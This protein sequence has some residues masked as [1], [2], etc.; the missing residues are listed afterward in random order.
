M[1]TFSEIDCLDV[2]EF[3]QFLK[4]QRKVDDNIIYAL[5]R[6]DSSRHTEKVDCA[7]MWTSLAQIHAERND[8][9]KRCVAVLNQ[10]I[11]EIESAASSEENGK[12]L[13]QF[14]SQRGIY[15]SE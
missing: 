11:G 15:E 12:K 4:S 2:I 9:I 13:R 10:K 14:K 7:V 6:A 1:T 3:Q 5:N 8:A